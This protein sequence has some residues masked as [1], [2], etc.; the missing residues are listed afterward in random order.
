MKKVLISFFLFKSLPHINKF[1]DVFGDTL[2]PFTNFM[3][4]V[5]RLRCSKIYSFLIFMRKRPKW[6]KIN[7]KKDELIGQNK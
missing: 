5:R 7:K 6:K 3:N 2:S 1:V 4:E